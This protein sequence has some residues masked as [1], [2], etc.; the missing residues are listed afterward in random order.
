MQFYTI[1]CEQNELRG[2]INDCFGS[3]HFIYYNSK[4]KQHFH[5]EHIEYEHIKEWVQEK[6]GT[7]DSFPQ[8][9]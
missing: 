5:N 1:D 2:I 4:K 3:P 9:D 8:I 6:R 7:Q